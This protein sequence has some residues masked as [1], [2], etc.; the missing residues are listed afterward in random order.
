MSML[1]MIGLI[2][3]GGMMFSACLC[4]FLAQASTMVGEKLKDDD[5]R[6]TAILAVAV[7]WPVALPAQVG[8]MVGR[9]FKNRLP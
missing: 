5:D 8:N 1:A 4:S 7:L 2:Y 9:A 3:V 6:A